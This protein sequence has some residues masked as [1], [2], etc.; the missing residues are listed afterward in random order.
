MEGEVGS[1]DVAAQGRWSSLL[2][3]VDQLVKSFIILDCKQLIFWKVRRMDS[4]AYI[5][6]A[7]ERVD[8]LICPKVSVAVDMLSMLLIV[9]SPF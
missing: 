7:R 6:Y 4:P 3:M 8:D 1:P 9:E 5:E 2:A